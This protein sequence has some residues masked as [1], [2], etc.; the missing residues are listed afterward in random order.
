MKKIIAAFDGLKYAESTTRY[1]IEIAKQT[2]AH[3]V[4]VFL[5]D[6]TYTSYKIYDLV[7]ENASEREL[8]RYEN[9]DRETR[10]NAVVAFQTACKSAGL[11]FSVHHDKNI[12]YQEL[13]HE[14]I[15]ADLLILGACET[16]THYEEELPTNFVKDILTDVQCPVVMLPRQYSPVEKIIFLYDGGPSSVH[17]VKM[18]YYLLPHLASLPTEIISVKG[19]YDSLH[20]PDNRLMK[21]L[22]KRHSPQA[23]Y[24]VLKGHA[25]KEI[26]SYLK[27]MSV[28]ALIVTGA[29]RRSRVSRWFKES[30]AD[31]MVRELSMPV[32]IAHNK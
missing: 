4:G 24:T 25:D 10:D 31:V 2:G 14:S 8:Q 16:L 11:G 20:V 6:F 5:E 21:E 13:L 22:M 18:F 28:N 29:Y 3:L 17:A 9:A 27:K 12:A 26:T 1:A 23:V 30:M 7:K 19:F 15:Y 32:L